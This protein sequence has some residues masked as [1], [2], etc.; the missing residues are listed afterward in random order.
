VS[1]VALLD[2]NVLWSA[3]V[4]DTLLLAVEHD[5]F[6][7]AWSERI[8]DEMARNLKSKRPDLDPARIDRTVSLMLAHFPEAVVSDYDKLIPGLQVHE[9]DRHVLAAAVRGRA[10]VIVTWNRAHFPERACLPHGVDVQDPDEFL[11]RLWDADYPE[12]VLVLREQAEHLA[13]P[14]LTALQVV[15]VLGR[16]VPRFAA[17]VTDS[18]LLAR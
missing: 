4:W 2:A 11:C 15:D 18:G 1:L 17:R 8:L 12:M 5:L 10:S 7:P 16:S 14:P 6:R 3:A 9:S 13:N